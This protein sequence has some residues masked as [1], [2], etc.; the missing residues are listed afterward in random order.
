MRD[1]L[2]RVRICKE[3]S[4]AVHAEKKDTSILVVGPNLSVAGIG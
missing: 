2:N 1:Q 4:S 3:G